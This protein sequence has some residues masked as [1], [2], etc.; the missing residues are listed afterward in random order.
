MCPVLF[1]RD[2]LA[3][4]EAGTITLAFRRWKRARVRP[5]SRLRTPV[6]VVGI[7]AVDVVDPDR[8]TE[9]DAR[10]AGFES[11]AALVRELDRRGEGTTYRIRLA[12]IGPDPRIALRDH[13]QLTDEELACVLDRLGR[14]D[15]AS[16][17]GP[18]TE[19]VLRLI[20]ARPETRAADLAATLGRERL[21][22]KRDVRELKELGL[23]ESLDVGYRL[24][25]RGRAVL[26]ALT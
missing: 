25:A 12:V 24:S 6:G 11:R 18:W 1:T 10:Q 8:I 26:E 9:R 4:L 19:Q 2:A 22:F 16:R 23:T 15:G 5:G 20:A 14:L 17:H 13:D 3:G 7:D 21:S